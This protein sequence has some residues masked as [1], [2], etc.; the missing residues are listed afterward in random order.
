MTCIDEGALKFYF[1]DA[2]W[3]VFKFDEH[4]DYQKMKNMLEG[5]KAVDFL[6]IRN[7][8]ELYL[9]EVKDFRH[10]RIENRDRLSK[11]ELA[12]EVAQKVRDS[13]SCIIGAYRNSENPDHWEP[14]MK[15]L[16]D[17]N[18]GVSVVVWLEHDL[19]DNYRLRRKA[20]FSTRT[21]VFKQKLV[22]LTSR[23]LVCARTGKHLPDMEVT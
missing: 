21:K 12:A 7:E 20:K 10:H 17:M 22:W 19:P 15:L 23:V 18:K 8:N 16:A 5:T 1:D 4:R 3:R 13:L 14:Y 6:G 2:K 9:I 11:G